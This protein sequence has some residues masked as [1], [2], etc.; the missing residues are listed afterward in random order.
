MGKM[1][2][3]IA[4]LV[5]TAIFVLYLVLYFGLIIFV[6][7]TI[8]A[9]ILLGFIPLLFCVVMIYVCVERI[10]EVRSNEEDDLSKY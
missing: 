10:K 7:P 5:I 6:V 9:K 8:F 3:I 2:K 4:P 1:K